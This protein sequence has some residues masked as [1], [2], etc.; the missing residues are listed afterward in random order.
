M[1]VIVVFGFALLLLQEAYAYIVCESH[2][3]IL[4]SKVSNVMAEFGIRNSETYQSK[5]R[6]Y[7]C[8][9]L[10]AWTYVME[11]C[12]SGRG[13]SHDFLTMARMMDAMRCA[14]CDDDELFFHKTKSLLNCVYTVCNWVVRQRFIR[15]DNYNVIRI[16]F[17]CVKNYQRDL[18]NHHEISAIDCSRSVRCLIL[19]IASERRVCLSIDDTTIQRS[20]FNNSVTTE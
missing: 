6:K 9:C 13:K 2:P 8:I 16:S 19:I 18:R 4:S 20:F 15:L 1:T 7:I 5:S 17:H 12:P 10:T 14:M 3:A 11:V